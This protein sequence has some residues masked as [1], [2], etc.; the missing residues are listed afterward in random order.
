MTTLFIE[1]S[2][3]EHCIERTDADFEKVFGNLLRFLQGK[4]KTSEKE[5]MTYTDPAIIQKIENKATELD[6]CFENSWDSYGVRPG[7]NAIHFCK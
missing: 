2:F 1:A 6:A 5:Y 4:S 7:D 3:P